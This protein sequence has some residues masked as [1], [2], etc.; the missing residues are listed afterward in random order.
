MYVYSMNSAI[1][2]KQVDSILS[3]RR[4]LVGA[5]L[6]EADIRLFVTLVRFDAVYEQ[7]FKVCNFILCIYIF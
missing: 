2:E 3:K 6:T 1:F 5:S 4:Y 7:H